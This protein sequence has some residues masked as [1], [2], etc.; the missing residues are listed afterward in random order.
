MVSLSHLRLYE[1]N[2]QPGQADLESTLRGDRSRPAAKGT[3]FSVLGS[4][5]GSG[6]RPPRLP[7]PITAAAA[8]RPKS[9]GVIPV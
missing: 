8:A 1:V 7:A 6:V 2:Q 3:S 5:R 4:G 9:F